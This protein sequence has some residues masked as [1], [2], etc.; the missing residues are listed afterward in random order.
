MRLIMSV[1]LTIYFLFRALTAPDFSSGVV[2][3]FDN[4]AI[5]MVTHA[6]PMVGWWGLTLLSAMVL[7][8]LVNDTFK[9]SE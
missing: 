6:P 3:G 2:G 8:Y 1:T 5:V 7:F 9:E 4:A